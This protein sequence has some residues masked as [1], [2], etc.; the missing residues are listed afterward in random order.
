[1]RRMGRVWVMENGKPAMAMFRTGPS[2]GR[3][4]QILP[5]DQLPNFARMQ[6]G[7]GEANPMAEEFKKAMERKLEAGTAVIVD[8]ETQQKK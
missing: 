3:M 7:N 6:N 2:D 5:L 1:M 4:T 8:S